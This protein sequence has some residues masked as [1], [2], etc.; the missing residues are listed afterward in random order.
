MAHAV[1]SMFY[2]GETPWHGLGNRVTESLSV[3]EAI[4]QAGLDWMVRK[5]EVI[6]KSDGRA[7]PVMA[8]VRESDNEILGVV[9]PRY[10]VLQND[11]AFNFFDQFVEN[12][13]VSLETAGSL[14]TG[15]K[16]WVLARI[17]GDSDISIVGDDVIRKFILLSNSHDGTMA[18]RVGFTP[19]RVVCANTLSMAH[20]N[21]ESQLIRLRH[22]RDV[23]QNLD[24]I[25]EIMNL[26]NQSFEATA[27]QFRRL[28]Q[29]QISVQDLKNYVKVCLG[30]EFV[31]DE[32]LSTRATNQIADV[33][34]L[35]E[36]GRGTELPGVKGTVWA[37]YNA[38][39]EFFTHEVSKDADKRYTSLW[40]GQNGNRNT[41][42]LNNALKL[43]A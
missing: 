1:E 5:E 2:Q 11:Q 35:F 24:G 32:D 17:S 27:E 23:V 33:I 25:K 38:V 7:V 13:M 43:A 16:V 36:N 15:K 22:S 31:N 21:G 19:I 6:L 10:H 37:A 18:V 29:K 39:T 28:A 34:R 14:D 40:F 42:A 41:T 9:G 12:K 4:K 8:T 20:S 26:A 30:Q 3:A